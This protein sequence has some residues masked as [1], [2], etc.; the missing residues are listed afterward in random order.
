MDW[1]Q[2]QPWLLWTEERA[3]LNRWGLE[4]EPALIAVDWRESQL[5]SLCL[6]REPA[7]IAVTK[8]RASLLTQLPDPGMGA[9]HR[10]QFSRPSVHAGRR[11]VV[12]TGPP[13]LYANNTDLIRPRRNE[14]GAM[15]TQFHTLS[16]VTCVVFLCRTTVVRGCCR[17]GNVNFVL[18]TKQT[19]K[20]ST[21]IC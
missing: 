7:L 18:T 2:S 14:T 19:V 15:A 10:A 3:S 8:E 1:R 6:K 16:T 17:R 5:W 21:A 11:T 12:L 4:R 9:M 20:P 13:G